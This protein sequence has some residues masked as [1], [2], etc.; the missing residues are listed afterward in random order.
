MLKQV[1]QL[2][3]HLNFYF[4]YILYLHTFIKIIINNYLH[5]NKFK[6]STLHN[7]YI[8]TYFLSKHSI[9]IMDNIKVVRLTMNRNPFINLFLV[10]SNKITLF[11]IFQNEFIIL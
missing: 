3:L 10:L 5:D 8:V 6:F 7:F 1:K 4:S 2:I 9:C 11:T